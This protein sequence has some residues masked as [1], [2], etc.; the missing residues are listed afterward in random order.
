VALSLDNRNPDR[1]VTV[2][3]HCARKKPVE[4]RCPKCDSTRYRPFGVGT[5]RI[6][7][8]ANERFP[9]ARVVR[10]DSDTT[11]RK[12]SHQ[13]MVEALERGEVDILVGTQMLA[14]GLDLPAMNVV[15]VVDADVGLNLPNLYAHERGFQLLSQVAGRAGRRDTPGQVFIQ[16]YDPEAA[17]IQCAANHDYHSFYE[18]EI[19][20]RRRAGYPPF[21]RL[22]RLT[23]GHGHEETGLMEASRVAGEIRLQ[24]D[25]A[26]RAEPDVLGPT[27][28]Y[29]YR[30]RGVYRWNILLRGRDPA[31]ILG[32]VRLGKG[33][34][35]DVDPVTVN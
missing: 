2:C 22:V 19:A 14:K 15:G 10:W 32:Q 27:Q 1:P 11:G 9:G 13:A 3:H 5:Q 4:D 35:V 33:W 16:T 31:K 20:H 24:R 25:A 17:P 6:E 29:I 21:T 30:L 26:G 7:L 23:F 28:A 8:E 12:G 18:H 34:T